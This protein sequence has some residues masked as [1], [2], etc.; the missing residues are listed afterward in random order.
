[1]NR[2]G[3]HECLGQHEKVFHVIKSLYKV[4]KLSLIYFKSIAQNTDALLILRTNQLHGAESTR[5]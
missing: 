4:T 1:M 2:T 3:I 5:T